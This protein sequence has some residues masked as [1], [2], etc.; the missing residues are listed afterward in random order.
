MSAAQLR[1]GRQ[2]DVLMDTYH[3]V[4][5]AR[6][7]AWCVSSDAGTVQ[8]FSKRHDAIDLGWRLTQGNAAAELAV[9]D[10]NGAVEMVWKYGPTES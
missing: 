9:H 8:W 7:N 10:S 6:R 3:V 4:L 2:K 1:R 5:D